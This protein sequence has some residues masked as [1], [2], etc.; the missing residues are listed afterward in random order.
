MC[1]K[2]RD[3]LAFD[4]AH[5]ARCVPCGFQCPRGDGAQAPEPE[6]ARYRITLSGRYGSIHHDV[7]TKLAA[8]Q[9]I[10][11]HANETQTARISPLALSVTK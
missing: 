10:A 2:C 4:V 8:R 6:P 9:W 5:F 7:A 11:R 1:P 3:Y